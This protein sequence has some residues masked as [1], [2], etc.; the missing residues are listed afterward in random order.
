MIMLMDEKSEN[1]LGQHQLNLSSGNSSISGIA[2]GKYMCNFLVPGF[3]VE[4]GQILVEVKENETAEYSISVS[5]QTLLMI[6]I[7]DETNRRTAV[8]L[9]KVTVSGSGTQLDLVPQLL[10]SEQEMMKIWSSTESLAVIMKNQGAAAII[11]GVPEGDYTIRIE[12]EGY[13]TWS[14]TR[15]IKAGGFSQ[16]EQIQTVA[17]MKNITTTEQ[18]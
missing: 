2:A 18:P 11:R 9:T 3:K 4:P 14:E 5:E 13:E 10:E 16:E 7:Q 1:M 6:M 17:T 15:A 8:P 12:A